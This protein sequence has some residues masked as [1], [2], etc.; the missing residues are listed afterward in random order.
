MAFVYEASVFAGIT[1]SLGTCDAFLQV[2]AA[3][4]ATSG[5]SQLQ[6]SR[7]SIADSISDNS[8]TDA[9]FDATN[10]LAAA[11]RSAESNSPSSTASNY[12]GA[13]TSL[14]TYFTT[15]TGSNIKDYWTSKSALKSITFNDNFRAMY[16]RVNSTELIQKLYKSDIRSMINFMQSKQ[17]IF[18]I[19]NAK[20]VKNELEFIIDDN[21]WETITNM[22]IKKKGVNNI[23]NLI[24]IS[25]EDHYK[26]HLS[27]SKDGNIK[28]LASVRLLS[29]R[30]N[31]KVC[32]LKGWTPSEE[33]K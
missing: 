2:A 23:E 31:K 14:N 20:N 5:L 18:K 29:Y 21:I 17:D 9:D 30:L 12:N 7:L 4:F 3:G 13:L 1:T 22:I 27:Q 25:I 11:F 19:E 16:R 10:T 28:D 26:L 6:T 24:C 33:T 32:D 15:I 8:I